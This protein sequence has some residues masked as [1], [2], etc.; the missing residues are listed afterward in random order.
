MTKNETNIV[1]YAYYSFQQAGTNN[2]MA[3][4]SYWDAEKEVVE[5]YVCPRARKSFAACTARATP[6]RAVLAPFRARLA[7]A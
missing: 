5:F 4:G 2:M 3:L 1:T 7:A 6:S